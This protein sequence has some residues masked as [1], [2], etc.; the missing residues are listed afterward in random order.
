M[1]LRSF[2]CLVCA[3]TSAGS[4]STSCPFIYRSSDNCL[5][6]NEILATGQH[7]CY[8]P[9]YSVCVY[10]CGSSTSKLKLLRGCLAFLIRAP[11]VFN[12][13][14]IQSFLPFWEKGLPVNRYILGLSSKPCTILVS[15]SV[16]SSA[17]T[18]NVSWLSLPICRLRPKLFSRLLRSRSSSPSCFVLRFT[19]QVFSNSQ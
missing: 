16:S 15:S 3:I 19:V 17:I 5:G 10:R 18:F 1:L 12:V 8:L 2:T 9:P 11:L 7:S 13:T 6:C 4:R 14:S